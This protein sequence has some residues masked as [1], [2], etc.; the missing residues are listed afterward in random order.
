MDTL[1]CCNHP[2]TVQSALD[3]HKNTSCSVSMLNSS[4]SPDLL[5]WDLIASP[6][7]HY[8]RGFPQPE[9]RS[10]CGALDVPSCIK[11][12]ARYWYKHSQQKKTKKQERNVP[13]DDEGEERGGRWGGRGSGGEYEVPGSAKTCVLSKELHRK[14]QLCI[15]QQNPLDAFQWI[16]I[17]QLQSVQPT[18]ESILFQ[19]A[20]GAG[21]VRCAIIINCP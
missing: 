21:I 6:G 20:A 15:A 3:V 14:V 8:K 16:L 18:T 2:H 12:P 5:Q 10:L 4:S 17:Q 9:R 1:N 7:E 19:E 13:E 11:K